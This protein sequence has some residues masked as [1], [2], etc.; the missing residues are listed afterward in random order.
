MKHLIVILLLLPLSLFSQLDDLTKHKIAGNI[1]STSVGVGM[2]KLTD[3]P[4]L[5]VSVGFLSGV[6]A[7]VLKE[8]YDKSHNGVSSKED[9]YATTWGSLIGGMIVIPIIDINRKNRE[10]RKLKFK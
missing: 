4:F 1:I 2:Y 6:L 10:L 7:G 9:I 3:K 8:Q 5:S